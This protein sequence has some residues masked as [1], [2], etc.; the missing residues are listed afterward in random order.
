MVFVVESALSGGL[1]FFGAGVH[2]EVSWA[3]EVGDDGGDRM[4]E[5]T[6]VAS[7]RLLRG[8]TFGYR[9]RLMHCHHQ[10]CTSMQR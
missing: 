2:K 1:G 8:L 3:V 7:Q 9:C 4:G 10:H 6:Q 5:T